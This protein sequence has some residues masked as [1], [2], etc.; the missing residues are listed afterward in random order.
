MKVYS[1]NGLGDF[2]YE[3]IRDITNTG[4]EVIVRGE[5][6]LEMRGPVVLEYTQ[7]GACW[8]RIPGRKFNPFFALAEVLWI[9]SG[10]GDAEWI[11]YF[12]KQMLEYLDEGQSEFHGAYGLRL[13]KWAAQRDWLN[14]TSDPVLID[15]IEH[16]VLK[17][18]AD[19]NTTQAIMSLW[20]PARDNLIKTKDI[21]CNNWVAYSLRDGKLDQ[22]VVIRSNDVLW[23]TPVNAIQFTHLHALVAGMLGVE[24]GTMTYFVQNLHY[25]LNKKEEVYNKTVGN[26]IGHAFSDHD[27]GAEA[28]PRF[29]KFTD[30]QV[31]MA[32]SFA[33]CDGK[34]YPATLLPSAY[35]NIVTEMIWL[36]RLVKEH[37]GPV[38]RRIELPEILRWL[39][40]DFWKDSLKAQ[41][42]I[43]WLN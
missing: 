17:I 4:R 7:P 3:I 22:S 9:L 16:V 15:Q 13:R 19:P 12:N 28:I 33:D 1:G 35:L 10:R 20:D 23:G 38:T 6:R 42:V 18:K 39:I 31:K 25:Y 26:I 41:E 8:M 29:E 11:G 5:T 43:Q 21:P 32:V 37:G 27:L 30:V 34:L 14:P 40:M 2:Y 36:Y 24:M